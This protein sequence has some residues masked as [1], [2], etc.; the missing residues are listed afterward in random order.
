MCGCGHVCMCA[1]VCVMYVHHVYF[2]MSVLLSSECMCVLHA[3]VVCARLWLSVVQPACM[4]CI[5]RAKPRYLHG[6][7]AH[8]AIAGTAHA[9][10]AQ[11][12]FTAAHEQ[13]LA[14][15][16]V[17]AWQQ[18]TESTCNRCKLQ[19]W[20]SELFEALKAAGG[21]A[22]SNYAVGYNNVKVPEA[23]QRG[24]PVGN[25]PGEALHG[26]GLHVSCLASCADR[27]RIILGVVG[28]IV[29]WVQLLQGEQHSWP[30]ETDWCTCGW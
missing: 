30:D 21:K 26:L 24:I 7:I 5:M 22:Y 6:A 9:T 13:P 2:V 12:G 25:T 11:C 14:A 17:C 29:S 20:G 1:H 10:A 23:S 28:I 3:C 18:H 27:H 15:S 19:D 4:M 8:E 16:G